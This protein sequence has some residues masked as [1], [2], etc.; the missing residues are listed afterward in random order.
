MPN[1]TPHSRPNDPCSTE[2]GPG[3]PQPLRNGDYM[4]PIAISIVVFAGSVVAA[5]G[6]MTEALI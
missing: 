6:A 1:P 5:G 4:K 3:K 2:S